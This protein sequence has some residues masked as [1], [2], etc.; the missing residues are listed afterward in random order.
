MKTQTPQRDLHRD[1]G[2]QAKPLA[3]VDS[4]WQ[5]ILK[6]NVQEG[7]FNSVLQKDEAV[8]RSKRPQRTRDTK[9]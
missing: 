1:K 3:T 5:S 2:A 9:T 4:Y 7:V 8:A 6:S